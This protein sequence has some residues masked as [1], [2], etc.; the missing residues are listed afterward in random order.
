MP[1]TPVPAQLPR[2]LLAAARVDG[3]AL[4][5][6][7]A[8]IK[9]GSAALLLHCG[10]G[11]TFSP[12]TWQV[13][14]GLLLAPCDT[15][16]DAVHRVTTHTA[17]LDVDNVTSYLD[18][19]DQH[20]PGGAI[21]RTFGFTVT[22]TAP[23]APAAARCSGTTGSASTR[24]RCPC[25]PPPRP[26]AA[27]SSISP[28]VTAPSRTTARHPW[29]P[30]YAPTPAGSTPPRPA[31]SC[32]S[33]TP[34]GCTGTTSATNSSTPDPASSTTPRRHTSTGKPPSPLSTPAAYPVPAVK[35]RVLRLA[36]S[37]AHGAPI[38]LGDAVTGLDHT[39]T[40][41]VVQAVLHAAGQRPA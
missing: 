20:H 6:V 8:V 9:H 14:T 34:P 41:L 38:N 5:H 10:D 12:T 29:P 3:V 37:L 27:I 26:Q 19:H 22:V 40:G 1:R 2:Q 4:V 16:I 36:A 39:N 7:A 31:A 21:L 24:R 15:L 33:T 25:P 32:S 23:P 17:G 28:P 11:D 13:P 30:S 35:A 18:H